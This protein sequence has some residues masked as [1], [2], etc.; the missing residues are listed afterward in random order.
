MREVLAETGIH[1]SHHVFDLAEPSKELFGV[2]DEATGLVEWPV[3]YQAGT[4]D[5]PVGT[6][7]P[8]PEVGEVRWMSFEEAYHELETPIDRDALVR[9]RLDLHG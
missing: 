5:Q 8:G 6:I 1:R 9:L 4:P 2:A 3:A 7:T